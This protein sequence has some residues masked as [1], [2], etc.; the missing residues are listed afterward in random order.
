M[1]DIALI[2]ARLLEM[3][4]PDHTNH[5]GTLFG[6]QALAWMDKAAFIVASRHARRAVVTARGVHP[7]RAWRAARG[8]GG[9]VH[10]RQRVA[11]EQRL[12]GWFSSTT[13]TTSARCSAPRAGVDG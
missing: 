4:F 5:L 2:E 11:A 3:V 9:L 12:L 7:E 6:G 8:E 13:P 10:P 1:T